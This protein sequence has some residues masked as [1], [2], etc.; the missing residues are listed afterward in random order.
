[1]LD[2]HG[3]SATPVARASDDIGIVSIKQSSQQRLVPR[4]LVDA[5]HL[6]VANPP[7]AALRCSGDPISL[8]NPCGC[9][10]AEREKHSTEY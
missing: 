9:C 7:G 3:I 2:Q 5:A 8:P 6:S 4:R 1:M 10:A